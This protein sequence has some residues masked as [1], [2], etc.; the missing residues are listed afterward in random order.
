MNKLSWKNF[1]NQAGHE[2]PP[3]FSTDVLTRV[4]QVR[5]QRRDLSVMAATLL[6]CVAATS[7]VFGWNAYR[8]HEQNLA[9]W[10]EFSAITVAME[11]SL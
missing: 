8:Q 9:E 5:R 2:L 1:Q 7:A 11:Q 6:F 3:G 4:R 10:R